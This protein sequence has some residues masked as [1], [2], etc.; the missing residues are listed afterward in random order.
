MVEVVLNVTCKAVLFDMDGTLVDSNRIV[1]LAWNRW[2]TRHGIP[3]QTVLAFSH[4]RPTLDTMQHFIPQRDHSE[5]LK[6]MERYEETQLEGIMA[7][8]GAID[9]V[10]AMR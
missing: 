4:G 5:E 8:P 10:D 6:E 2:A 7:V 9:V 3:L 1:E